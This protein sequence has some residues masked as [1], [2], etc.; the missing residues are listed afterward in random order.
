MGDEIDVI[1]FIANAWKH[2]PTLVSK[3]MY[4]GENVTPREVE[5]LLTLRKA[6][7]PVSQKGLL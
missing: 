6:A 7:M 3:G 1:S 5:Y 4:E 2:D